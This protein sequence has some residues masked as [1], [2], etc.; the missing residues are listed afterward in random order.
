[1]K[2]PLGRRIG[3]VFAGIAML[4]GFV[5]VL[6]RSGP[7]API[8]I[9]TT[10]AA[11]TDIAPTLFG[12]GVVEARR[13]YMIGP[14]SA[15]RVSRVAVDVGETVRADQ[16]LAEMDPVDLDQRIAAT[17]AAA[18]RARNAVDS[19]TALLADSLARSEIAATNAR[20]Y[21][22]L[23]R[24][25]FVSA[26]VSEG[27]EL[28]LKSAAA[29]AAAAEAS[30]AGAR[31]DMDRLNAE[32]DG[33][34]RQ[35]ANLR[36]LAPADG[37]ISARDAEPGSTVVAGQAVLRMIA[38]DSLWVKLRV[39]QNRSVGLQVGLPAQI[40]LRSRPSQVLTGKV[41][42]IELLS[43]SVTEERIA[44]IAFDSQP[45]DVSVGEMS[46]VSLRLPSL[47][48]ALAVPNAALRQ[49]AGKTGVWVLAND[50]LR[51]VA[52]NVGTSGVDG[53]VQI[54]EGIKEGDEIVVHSER[55]IDERSR[56]KV[57]AALVKPD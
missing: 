36:L 52:V 7:L 46:E 50:Q 20:R 55:D 14:T 57:V 45:K 1:M 44:Q 49:R 3:L 27:K 17:A 33:A 40:V 6:A 22:D 9:T 39:D 51:F 43:D 28:E 24:K 34:R 42:R 16:L 10:P 21:D 38:A 2:A 13:A 4:A 31:Q 29:Q 41:A 53:K 18:A 12:I 32:R 37:V 25:G 30:L 54:L 23:G 47:A 11:R 19:A 5:W 48:Q 56:V 8:R 15:G 26:S 35:R